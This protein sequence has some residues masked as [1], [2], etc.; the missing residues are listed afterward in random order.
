MDEQNPHILAYKKFAEDI[1]G[2]SL[3]FEHIGGATDSR[4]F[5]VKGSTVIMHSGSG[6]G[7]HANGEY[8][9]VDSVK[10]IAEIQIRFLEKM[11]LAK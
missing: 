9:E 10:K 11:A 4:E 5:A 7:M 2:Q 1:L 3:D 6:E 8:V